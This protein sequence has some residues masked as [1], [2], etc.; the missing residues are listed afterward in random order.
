MLEVGEESIGDPDKIKI[1]LT[2]LTSLR[3][4]QTKPILATKTI[5]DP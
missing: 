1:I 5:T 2:F 4:I 3:S